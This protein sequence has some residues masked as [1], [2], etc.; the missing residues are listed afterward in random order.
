[1]GKKNTYNNLSDSVLVAAVK[2]GD[3]NAFDALFLRWY[4]QVL[5]F[6]QTLVK[7]NAI[8]EDL[9]QTVLISVEL[10]SVCKRKVIGR[11]FNEHK[12]GIVREKI[13]SAAA[14]SEIRSRTAHRC[15]DL[16][17]LGFG[18]ALAQMR[19]QFCAPRGAVPFRCARAL[20][21]RSAKIT[22]MELFFFL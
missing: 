7:D 22:Y 14:K 12:I 2:E 20:G 15:H 13:V 17:D 8:A 5:K 9:S 16:R 3:T 6:I 19:R 10:I 4:P 11:K 1:M 18:I 21:D